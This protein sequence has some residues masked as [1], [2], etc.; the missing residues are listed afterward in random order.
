MTGVLQKGVL[1]G[2]RISAEQRSQF[3][4][5]LDQLRAAIRKGQTL[6]KASPATP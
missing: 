5:M 6:L 2:S 1:Y 3:K 4:Q